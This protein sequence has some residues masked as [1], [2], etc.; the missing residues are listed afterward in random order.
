MGLTG[1]SSQQTV[2]AASTN[3]SITALDSALSCLQ[4]NPQRGLSLSVPILLPTSQGQ[5][6]NP[7]ASASCAEGPQ[8]LCTHGLACPPPSLSLQWFMFSKIAVHIWCYL[9]GENR[10]QAEGKQQESC[11][12]CQFLKTSLFCMGFGGRRKAEFSISIVCVCMS[13]KACVRSEDNPVWPASS[14]L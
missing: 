14:Y 7:P 5:T 8:S 9:L 6:G 1:R 11:S 10:A 12:L 3:L 2:S 13:R 4:K